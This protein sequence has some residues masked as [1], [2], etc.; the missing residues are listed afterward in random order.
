M[1]QGRAEA[2][3]KLTNCLPPRHHSSQLGL[4]LIDYRSSHMSCPVLSCS[5]LSCSALSCEPPLVIVS[6]EYR[7][8]ALDHRLS[9]PPANQTHETQLHSPLPHSTL[10]FPSLSLLCRPR[11]LVLLFDTA[12]LVQVTRGNRP[13]PLLEQKLAPLRQLPRSLSTAALSTHSVSSGLTPLQHTTS[14]VHLLCCYLLR[15]ILSVSSRRNPRQPTL[16]LRPESD[17]RNHKRQARKQQDGSV[18][19]RRCARSLW[20]PIQR[21]ASSHSFRAHPTYE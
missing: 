21:C 13:R 4:D 3:V 10:Y 7:D 19:T 16:F 12:L 15:L 9:L 18:G 14:Q 11:C 6:G 17:L 1:H 5:V 20:S 2:S 8:L